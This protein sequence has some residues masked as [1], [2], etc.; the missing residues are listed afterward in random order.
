MLAEPCSP[1][2]FDDGI[3]IRHL[4]AFLLGLGP[5]VFLYLLFIQV[6]IYS[7]LFIQPVYPFNDSSLARIS[8]AESPEGLP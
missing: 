1:G 3:M 6:Y 5:E 7:S 4:R 2:V 8:L